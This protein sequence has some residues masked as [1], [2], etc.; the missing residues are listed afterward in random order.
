MARR[1]YLVAWMVVLLMAL[2]VMN[3][4]ERA[5]VRTKLAWGSVFMPL[6]GLAG[7]VQGLAGQA[8]SSFLPRSLLSRQI[9]ALQQENEA[10][11]FQLVQTE[12][13]RREN[14]RLRSAVLWRESARWNL[15]LARVIG[16]DPSSW[17][18]SVMIDL[19]SREGL[20]PD[21][22]VLTS[23][24]LVGRVAE[25]GFT[26]SRVVLVGDPN[27][28]FSGQTAETRD[29]GIVM[30]DEG[31]FDRQVVNFVYVP[32][33]VALKPGMEVVTS[34]DGPVFPKGLPVGRIIDVQTNRFGLYL[35]ARLRL[36]ADLNR[37]EEVWV[38]LP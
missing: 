10:L 20:E 27:C 4:P 18:R 21:M 5:A 29:K 36:G 26:R 6:F 24:G 33:T 3:L 9:T 25:V 22:P 14:D 35:E 11:R 16:Q 1:P 31:S 12:Q 34:G 19:G 38:M 15:R 13:I 2:A 37:L 17:W 28:R 30:P 7:S 8:R 32:T 23:R